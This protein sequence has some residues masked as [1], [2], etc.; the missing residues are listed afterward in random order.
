ML[1]FPF[2]D[3]GHSFDRALFYGNE[4]ALVVFDTLLFCIIDLIFQDF[5]LAGVLTYVITEE[6]CF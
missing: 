6:Y 3:D 2:A 5:V 4:S 1:Y